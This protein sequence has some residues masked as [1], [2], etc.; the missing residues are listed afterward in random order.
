M[1]KIMLSN[2]Y[3]IIYNVSRIDL[4]KRLACPLRELMQ[5]YFVVLQYIKISCAFLIGI[6]LNEGG[7]R[8][9]CC[10]FLIGI[11]F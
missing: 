4:I 10:A 11:I 7:K 5:D 3:K 9:Q 8:T 6:S 1:I 2:K